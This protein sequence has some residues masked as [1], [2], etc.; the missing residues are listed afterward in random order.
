MKN[1]PEV[2]KKQTND[3]SPPPATNAKPETNKNQTRTPNQPTKTKHNKP[4]THKKTNGR[5]IR[6]GKTDNFKAAAGSSA[7]NGL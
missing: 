1:K 3:T 2:K 5:D 4:H 6:F 7:V